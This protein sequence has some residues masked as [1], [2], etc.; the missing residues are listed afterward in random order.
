M[1]Q[2][3]M[4]KATAVWLVENTSLTFE[5]IAEF[6]QLHTLEVQGIA[7]GEVAVGIRGM[8]PIANSQI[9]RAELERCEK[10]SSKSLRFY[11]QDD[12]PQPSKRTK[13]PR[14]TPIA[15]RQDKPDGI[16]WLVRHHPELTDN[17]V[18]KL[19]GTTKKTIQAIRD[20]S[21]W[22]IS[23][24]RPR[25]PVL[26]GLCKQVDLN[27][28]IDKAIK[29]AEKAG[30]IIPKPEPMEEEVV[31]APVKEEVPEDPYEAFT[32]AFKTTD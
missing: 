23:N 28:T 14:Y 16:A 5:Q 1:S 27:A 24:I 19:I 4:P 13:G 21:H 2:P 3:L 15:K 20:R 9:T 22:N 29:E 10:D 25:D 12:L 11:Q 8:D 31:E 26:L 30:R 7:D 17:H 32:R 6:C 18:S